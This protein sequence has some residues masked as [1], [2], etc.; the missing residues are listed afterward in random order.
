[1]LMLL[2]PSKTLDLS[3]MKGRVR[4]TQPALIGETQKLIPLLK[5]M[6]RAEIAKLMDISPKLAELNHA[7]Y[8]AF[9]YPYPAGESK[10]ALFMFKGDVYDPMPIEK[11]TKEDLAFATKHLRILSGLYGILRPLDAMFPYRL[12]MGTKLKTPRGTTLYDFWGNRISE[13]LNKAAKSSKS[14]C[15][16]NLASEEYVSAVDRAA[17]KI[18]VI[19]IQFR[20]FKGGSYKIVGLFA[21]KARGM[22]ADAVIRGRITDPDEL[23]NVRFAGYAFDKGM[24]K[25]GTLVFTRREKAAA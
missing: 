4:E 14:S 8:Q 5:K 1:M 21:K 17:L 6:S 9:A 16:L 11:Y 24:S 13:E 20:D 23:R 10:P 3:P 12:E 2:S 22:M 25:D 18:P 15:I 7:R 19:D